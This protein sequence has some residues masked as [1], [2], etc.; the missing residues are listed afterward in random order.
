M[1]QPRPFLHLFSVSMTGWWRVFSLSSQCWYHDSCL[2]VTRSSHWCVTWPHNHALGYSFHCINCQRHLL[3]IHS[4]METKKMLKTAYHLLRNHLISGFHPDLNLYAKKSL[5]VLKRQK[6][7]I[8]DKTY[9]Q[10]EFWITWLMCYCQR[11][12]LHSPNTSIWR[13]ASPLHQTHLIA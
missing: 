4:S 13:K 2:S 6:C 12:P 5:W 7:V 8:F 11:F 3:V 10:S 1:N 9:R